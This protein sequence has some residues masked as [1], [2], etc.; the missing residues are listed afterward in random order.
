MARSISIM[1]YREENY[2]CRQFPPTSVQVCNLQQWTV[3]PPLYTWIIASKICFIGFISDIWQFM[4]PHYWYQSLNC[5]PFLSHGIN[6]RLLSCFWDKVACI[7]SCALAWLSAVNR[8]VYMAGEAAFNQGVI[9]SHHLWRH[10]RRHRD[11]QRKAA[12][13]PRG[14]RS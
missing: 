8:G 5:S 3:R 14:T 9:D 6:L 13:D 11:S 10:S 2:L 1:G 4:E 12:F 7:W